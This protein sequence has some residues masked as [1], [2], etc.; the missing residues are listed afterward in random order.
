[1]A[2]VNTFSF[3]IR[4]LI[5]SKKAGKLS[6]RKVWVPKQYLV[7]V[8]RLKNEWAVVCIDP[9]PV[10][11]SV[12]GIQLGIEKHNRFSKKNETFTKRQDE[13]PRRFIPLKE[14]VVE[15]PTPPWGRFISPREKDARRFRDCSSRK[16]A[17][18]PRDKF[19]PLNGKI[20]GKVNSLRKKVGERH[21]YPLMP[22][23]P[24]GGPISPRYIM[25]VTRNNFTSLRGRFFSLKEKIADNFTFPRNMVGEKT[26][27]SSLTYF[28]KR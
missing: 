13:F 2:L 11:N 26:C 9:P 22:M 14:K 23:F 5:E 10:R 25:K 7:H 8:D 24:K 3:D 28:S 21:V 1:M 18:S 15:R 17:F 19:T 4:A 16:K 20:V 27:F 6:H 12:K